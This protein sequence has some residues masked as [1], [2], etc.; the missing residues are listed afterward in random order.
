MRIQPA[1]FAFTLLLGLLASVPYSGIDMSLPALAATVAALGA[2]PADV[3]FTMSVFMLSLAT[4]PLVYGPVSDRYGRRPIVVFGVTLF[5]V[6]SLACALAQSLPVLLVCRFGQGCGAA[7]TTLTFAI[8]RDLFEGDNA[9][10]KMANVVIAINV[11]T[12]IAPTA[13]AAL[14]ALG[15]WRLIYTIQFVMGLVLLIALVT[16]FAESAKIDQTNRLAPSIIGRS[17]LQ[18][19]RHPISFAYILVGAAAGGTVMAY[20]T[21]SSLFFIN[22]MGLRPN[23]YGLIFSA[24]SGSVMAG[25]FL[26]RRLVA[27][28]VSPAYV[29]MRGLTVSAVASGLLLATTL[30]GWVPLL[31]V[32]SLL[33][34]VGLAF[35]LTIPNAIRAT[36]HPLPQ[37]AGAVGAVSGSIQMMAGAVSSGLVACLYDGRSALSMAAVMTPCSL[38][39]LASVPPSVAFSQVSVMPA[40][41]GLDH[42]RRRCCHAR[43]LRSFQADRN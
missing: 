10:A 13:G 9:R 31:L 7:S 42:L 11:V 25:A 43:R 18:V 24:C 39:A 33:V 36:M 38:L 28:N 22:S 19:L 16:G 8:I 14:L 15:S 27:W 29:L 35:G 30:V 23:R 41:D 20:V 3:G 1:S 34:A 2:P 6:G 40:L 4:A 26:D 32:V 21:G 5:V 37:I 17:Y 12:L